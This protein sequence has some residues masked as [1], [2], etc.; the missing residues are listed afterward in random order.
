MVKRLRLHTVLQIK[1]RT[2]EIEL[3]PLHT[4]QVKCNYHFRQKDGQ[5]FT[6]YLFE[7]FVP[8]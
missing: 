5:M 8:L 3:T 1:G 6:L 2:S 7:F 4:Q